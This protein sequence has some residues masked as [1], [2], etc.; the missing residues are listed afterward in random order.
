MSENQPVQNFPDYCR[1]IPDAISWYEPIN[2]P[3]EPILLYEGIAHIVTNNNS[4]A[5][6]ARIA[7]EWLPT[8]AVRLEALNL[9]SEIELTDR[10]INIEINDRFIIKDVFIASIESENHN[11]NLYG[12][13]PRGFTLQHS[14]ITQHVIFL[15]PNFRRIA[16]TNVKYKKCISCIGRLTLRSTDWNITLDAIEDMDQVKK[17]LDRRSGFAITHIGKLEKC[18]KRSFSREE[19]I[20]LLDALS[21]YISFATGRWTGPCLPT[22]F[23]SEMNQQWIDWSYS[24]TVSCRWRPT[25]LDENTGN[26]FSEPYPGFW[27]LWNKGGWSAIIKLAIHYY[28]EANSQ[29]GSIEGSIALTQLAFELLA[30]SILVEEHKWLSTDGYS[31]L[32]AADTIRLLLK[33]AGIPSDIP[34]DQIE[35]NKLAK[36]SSDITDGPTAICHIRNKIIHPVKKNRDSIQRINDGALLETWHLGLWYLE[37]CVLRLFEY[38]GTY[39]NRLK[40]RYVGDVDQVPWATDAII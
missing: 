21:W 8:P 13:V 35:L 20:N 25:W 15:L 11:H 33:W 17:Q 34:A 23:D 4:L 22:G 38:R 2:P 27:K 1:S 36:Q 39:G 6:N 30:S 19:A 32:Q 29:A 31:K 28:I 24:R 14:D 12:T 7:L 26:Q 37:L 5:T 9:Q 18:D 10:K 16:G 3:N 40:H